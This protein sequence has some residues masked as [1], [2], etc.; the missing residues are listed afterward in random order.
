MIR[1]SSSCNSL[2]TGHF[3]TP[4]TSTSSTYPMCTLTTST[5]TSILTL[6]TSTYQDVQLL[7]RLNKLRSEFGNVTWFRNI[8]QVKMDLLLKRK[9][10]ERKLDKLLKC[11]IT[12]NSGWGVRRGRGNNKP[13]ILLTSERNRWWRKVQYMIVQY[14]VVCTFKLVFH[15]GH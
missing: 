4:P 7:F 15:K 14:C 8:Q 2:Y 12:L 1:Q 3:P 11:Q 9:K 6:P 5:S 13:L 10:K